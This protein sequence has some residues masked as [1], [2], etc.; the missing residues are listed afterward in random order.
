M[1]NL[2]HPKF[3]SCFWV[4][5][6]GIAY[7]YFIVPWLSGWPITETIP[8]KNYQVTQYKAALPLSCDWDRYPNNHHAFGHD[9]IRFSPNLSHKKKWRN[10][11][12]TSSLMCPFLSCFL[13]VK[14]PNDAACLADRIDQSNHIRMDFDDDGWMVRKQRLHFRQIRSWCDRIC[15][16][17]P[18]VM[19]QVFS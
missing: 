11:S 6:H 17:V 5:F 14:H 7:H 2:F 1:G 12:I 10:I 15:E 4:K 18:D 8:R 13:Q 3:T 19:L 9:L 16:G